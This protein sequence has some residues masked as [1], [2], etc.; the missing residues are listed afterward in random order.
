MKHSGRPRRRMMVL[1]IAFI[2]SA[3]VLG[4]LTYRKYARSRLAPSVPP[5]VQEAGTIVV[6]L[7]FADPAGDGLRREAREIDA[8]DDTASC[9]EA[10]L[11]ELLNGPVGDM[12]PTLPGSFSL[13]SVEV[14]NDTAVLD[15]EAG[16][17]KGLP[18]GSAA[19]LAAVYSIIDTIAFNF[20][21]I[22]QVKFLVEGGPV[23]T[24]KGHI[25]LREPLAP[26]FSLEKKQ[27]TQ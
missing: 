8:C 18:G 10:L 5:V 25:D 13:R 14:V 24:L 11:D 17:E 7:F 3:A 9:V 15:L 16:S 1:F 12:E 26:D 27:G 2:L 6:T 21:R 4:A 20:P 19:E 22:K 23:S